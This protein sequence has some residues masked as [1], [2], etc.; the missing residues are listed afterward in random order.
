MLLL[1]VNMPEENLAFLNDLLDNE[2]LILMYHASLG[3]DTPPSLSLH[4]R[5]RSGKTDNFPAPGDYN[6]DKG[7]KVI[8]DTAPKYTFGLKAGRDK[9][10]DT[11]GKSIESN[12]NMS[13]LKK[14][15]VLIIV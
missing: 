5:P 9:T 4:S 13:S 3:K 11:P 14:K 12:K 8:K 1:L 10:S 6:P 7:D 2:N 15:V